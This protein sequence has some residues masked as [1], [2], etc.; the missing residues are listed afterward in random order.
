MVMG[1]VRF[2]NGPPVP[3]TAGGRS[4]SETSAPMPLDYG[5]KPG[6]GGLP[7]PPEMRRPWYVNVKPCPPL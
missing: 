1:V 5:R 3:C 6:H 7:S 2:G 4:I